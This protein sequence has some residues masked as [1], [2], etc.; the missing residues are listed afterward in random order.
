[1]ILA[2]IAA[3]KED[4]NDADADNKIELDLSHRVV[5]ARVRSAGEDCWGRRRVVELVSAP[6]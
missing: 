4:G 5:M 6:L 2:L 3:G 1:M